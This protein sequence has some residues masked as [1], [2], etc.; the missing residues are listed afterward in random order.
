MSD[1]E[2]GLREAIKRVY[3]DVPVRG[4]WFHFSQAVRR[5]AASLPGFV[6]GIRSGDAQNDCFRKFMVLPLV[7][8]GQIVAQF[9]AMKAEAQG[10][11]DLFTEFIA[12]YENQWI[13]EVCLKILFK[14]KKVLFV[15]Q[16]HGNLYWNC[17]TFRKI[18]KTRGIL[19]VCRRIPD[20]QFR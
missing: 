13:T 9:E 15:T 5:K 20:Q 1:F 6:A 18:D 16:I 11:G 10:F 7:P 14:S 3:G 2:V 8:A 12:Y 17:L 4:C 19:C